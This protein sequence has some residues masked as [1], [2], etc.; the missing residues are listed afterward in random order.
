LEA[1]ALG[2]NSEQSKK[3]QPRP[4]GFWATIGFSCVIATAYFFCGVVVV[5]AFVIAAKSQSPELDVAAFV[6]SLSAN[7]SF[8]AL[9][10]CVGGSCIIILCVLF[11]KIRRNISV[12]EYLCLHM[13]SLKSLLKWS[14]VLLLFLLCSDL[15][16]FA[17]GRSIVPEFMV[18]AY[19][20]AGFRP[21]LWFALVIA[22]PVSEEIFFRG[23]LFRGIESSIIGPVGAVILTSLSWAAIHTQY[24]LYGIGS[25]AVGGL[26]LGWAR[27]KTKS[28]WLPVVMHAMQNLLAT[29]EVVVLL[30][31]G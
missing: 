10:A 7:G 11:A 19:T 5:I 18:D 27:L 8:L 21:L 24:D 23:F 29:I 16:T 31:I 17:L 1:P 2:P 20:T 9:F 12:G 14:L 3:Q 15:L 4:W 25:I 22:A 30:H 6:N 13:P 28:I 26:L